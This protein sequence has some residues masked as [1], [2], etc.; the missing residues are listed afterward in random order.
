M[1]PYLINSA[2]V[3]IWLEKLKQ[4]MKKCSAEMCSQFKSGGSKLVIRNFGEY[5]SAAAV[6]G[7]QATLGLAGR[8]VA[9][10]RG[11][12]LGV[13]PSTVQNHLF[14]IGFMVICAK[15]ARCS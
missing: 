15:L 13:S 9:V 11:G 8:G 6:V 3:I 5:G 12:N 14:F 10:M 7:T 1:L 2:V 4:L